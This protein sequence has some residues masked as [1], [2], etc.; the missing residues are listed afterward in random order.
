MGHRC[1]GSA[2]RRTVRRDHASPPFVDD[3]DTARYQAEYGNRNLVS[4]LN[5]PLGRHSR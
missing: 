4:T 5:P 1:S 2:L 3:K